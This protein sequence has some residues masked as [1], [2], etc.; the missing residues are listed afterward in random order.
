ME[1]YSEGAAR[2]S[3]AQLSNISS[4][5]EGKG[6]NPSR[7]NPSLFIVAMGSWASAALQQLPAR[8]VN[9]CI[10]TLTSGCASFQGFRR[11]TPFGFLGP[12]EFANG[13]PRV[14]YRSALQ[15]H[16]RR[17]LESYKLHGNRP[18]GNVKSYRVGQS[19]LYRYFEGLLD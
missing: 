9:V 11:G 10:C 6:V 13:K 1:L 17:Y 12:L 8:F 14:G 18:P 19:V 15:E 5:V 4:S 7:G 3:D 2:R 16:I